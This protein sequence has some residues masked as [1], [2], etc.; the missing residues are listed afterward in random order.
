MNEHDQNPAWEEQMRQGLDQLSDLGHEEPPNLAALQM[1]VVEVQAEQRRKLKADLLKFWGVGVTL[2]TFALA[3]S[4]REPL[5]FLAW[6]G[7][8]ALLGL[9]GALAWSGTKKRVM[10]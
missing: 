1:L 6:Q 5:Y 7:A 3:A 2:L 4:A 8:A 9:V 10:E